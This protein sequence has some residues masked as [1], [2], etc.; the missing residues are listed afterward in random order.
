MADFVFLQRDL[1]PLTVPLARALADLGY[2]VRVVVVEELAAERLALGWKPPDIHGL[3][4]VSLPPTSSRQTIRAFLEPS[5]THLLQGLPRSGLLRRVHKELAHRKV[6]FGSIMEQVDDRGLKGSVKRF[7]YATRL[8][9]KIR[10]HFVLGIGDRAPSWFEARSAGKQMIYPFAYFLEGRSLTLPL[11]ELGAFRIGYVGQ[12]VP[13]KRVDLLLEAIGGIQS[14][15]LQL[16]LIGGGP[17]EESLRDQARTIATRV[18]WRGVVSRTEI[19]EEMKEFDVLVLP[20]AFDGWGAVVSE[21]M[22]VGVP[23]ICSSACG[24]SVA[25]EKA[26]YGAVFQQGSVESLQAK[27]GEMIERGPLDLAA[28]NQLAMWARCLNASSGARYLEDIVRHLNEPE[29][30]RPR[31]PWETFVE[32]REC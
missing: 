25:V 22:M 23:V 7:E 17:L 11:R 6:I 1:S 14:L 16:I 12:L 19:R 27:L 26:P 20:S 24:A 13:R 8:R 3:E 28:R 31:A 30:P 10:P 9:G 32:N 15:A 5:G 21:A 2:K 18:V 4:V 29:S